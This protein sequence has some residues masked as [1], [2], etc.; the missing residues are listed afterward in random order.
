MVERTPEPP[1]T[2]RSRRMRDAAR[3]LWLEHGY[4][5]SMDAVA[6]RAGCS[7]QT[8][9]AHFGSK[10]GLFREV[11]AELISPLIA[12][13]DL[14]DADLGASLLAFARAHAEQLS[15]PDT[16]ARRRILISEAPRF[17]DEAEVLWQ[18]GLEAIQAHLATV[19]AT[20][21]QR[22]DLRVDDPAAAAEVF[23]GLHTGIEGER[24][25][26]GRTARP[27]PAARAAWAAQAVDFFLRLYA[28]ATPH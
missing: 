26:F 28:P 12:S 13:L 2:D 6:R 5:T 18:S 7:K 20:A 4:R 8:V 23:L 10:E 11:V 15:A 16:V 1:V 24:L 25:F 21:M 27:T 19:I 14:H 9:Y 22:G 17:P 3:E